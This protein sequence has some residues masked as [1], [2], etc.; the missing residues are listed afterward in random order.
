MLGPLA[1]SRVILLLVLHESLK[2]VVGPLE[3]LR[4]V[5]C[6]NAF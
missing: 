4:E 1:T 5:R 3:S 6:R 2:E